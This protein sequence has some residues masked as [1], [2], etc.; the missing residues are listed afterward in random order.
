MSK[1]KQLY[2]LTEQQFWKMA[3]GETYQGSKEALDRVNEIKV[4]GGEPEIYYS[5]FSGFI[6][7]DGADPDQMERSIRLGQKARPYR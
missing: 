5:E 3:D 1:S 4:K 6:I 7:V 2:S